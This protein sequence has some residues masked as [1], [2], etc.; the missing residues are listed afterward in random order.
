MK[1]NRTTLF[2]ILMLLAAAST[3]DAAEKRMTNQDVVDMLKAKMSES[4][5]LM[6][7]RSSPPGFDTSASG[8]I[9]LSTASAS[10]K[11]MQAVIEASSSERQSASGAA[12]SDT[13]KASSG[14]PATANPEEVVLLDNGSRSQMKYL[15]PQIRTAARAL[16]FGGVA[17][18]AALNGAKATLRIKSTQPSFIVAIPSNAQPESY[19]TIANFAVRKNGSREVSVG[20]GY[21][22]YSTGIS[23]DRVIKANA[24][25][26]A[27]QSKAPKDFIIYRITPAAPMV[28]GEYAFILYNSQVKVAGYF[29]TGLDSYFDFG[30]D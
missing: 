18:Y 7:I 24:E 20:G 17:Q 10:D 25:K 4:T 15:A 27:D 2:A 8:L 11:I 21:I 30:I 26:D 19:F 3:I 28:P 29:A 16:G 1:L 6:A 22:S 13:G 14:A 9:K 12:V 23:K 5:I